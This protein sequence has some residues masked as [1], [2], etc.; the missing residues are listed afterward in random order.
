[1]AIAVVLIFAAIFFKKLELGLVALAIL[2]AALFG[3]DYCKEDETGR[4]CVKIPPAD[5]SPVG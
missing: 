2:L 3:A 5:D 1:V 4:K